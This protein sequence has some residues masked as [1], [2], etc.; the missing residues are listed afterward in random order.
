MGSK[1]KQTET[2]ADN[3]TGR[4]KSTVKKR[5]KNQGV[6]MRGD[7]VMEGHNESGKKRLEESEGS[8]RYYE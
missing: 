1:R 3:Q 8:R 6:E 4:Q 2:E 5:G 7:E